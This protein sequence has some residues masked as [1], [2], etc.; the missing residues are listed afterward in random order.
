MLLLGGPQ[1]QISP[2]LQVG[3]FF[4][5]V[6]AGRSKLYTYISPSH[7]RVAFAQSHTKQHF[8]LS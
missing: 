8:V 6:A 2:F 1:D 7:N 5:G 3:V 4:R